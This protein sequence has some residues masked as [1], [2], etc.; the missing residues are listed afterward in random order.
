M[1]L[2]EMSPD[3]L[4]QVP[5]TTFTAEQVLERADLQRL[6]RARIETV[7]DG[8]LIVSEEFG[9]FV[10]ARR[11]IDLLGV[12]HSGQ[13]V[14]FELK[15]TED[16]GHLELQA[17]RYA[18]MVSVMTFEDLLEHYEQHLARIDPDAVRDAR[19]RLVAWLDDAA[20]ENTV[21]SREVRIVLISAGFD[22]EI[23]TTVLWLNDVY[24][25]DIRCVRLTPYKVGERL[26]LDVQQVIPLPEA[27]ELTIQLRRRQ[28]QA[29][30]VRGGDG[31]DW[32]QYVIVTPDGRTD[33][34]RKRRAVLALVQGL[35]GAGV[36]TQRLADV[37]PASNF[38]AV[39]GRLTGEHLAEAVAERYPSYGRDLGWLF[40]DEPIHD[41]D[42]TWVLSKRWGT[43][44]EHT[45]ESLVGLA[46]P[47][48]GFGYE[49]VP[50]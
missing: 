44:T 10:G 49:P 33:P 41:A 29:R 7:M 3:S 32:T 22:R 1:P 43:N 34:L 28:S 48:T 8:V 9:A 16:G 25:L 30:A 19:S 38:V 47:G 45:L 15:R 50:T 20:G 2:F 39:D 35:H 21:L 31:R 42:H 40:L 27:S 4:E 5:S 12:D 14:V 6:L 23:T 26:L 37:L 46:P 11:R 17:L 13:L 36:A 18:A 24:G